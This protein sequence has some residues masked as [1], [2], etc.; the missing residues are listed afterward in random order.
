M[1]G[2]LSMSTRELDRLQVLVRV[3]E[4]RLTQREAARVLGVTERQLRRLW[5]AY[6]QRGAAGLVSRKRGRRSNR[7]LADALREDA[8]A[9]VRERYSDFGPTFAHEK[10]TEVHGLGVSVSTLRTWMADSGLWVPRVQRQRSVHQ[11][12]ARRECYG[13]LI[14]IDGSDHHWFEE[15]AGRCTLLVFIDDATGK[16]MELRFC[17]GESTFNYFEAAKSYLERHGKPVAFYSDKASVFRVNAKQPSAGD[18]YT[19]FGR[20]MGELNIDTMCA[21]TPQ[22]KGRVERANSTLQNRLVKELRL[23]NISSIDGA[24]RFASEF[25]E[26]FNKRFAHPALNPHDAHRPLRSDETLQKVFTWQETRKVTRSLTLHYKRAMYILD[27]SDAARRAMGKHVTLY[28]TED[29]EVSIVHDG[30]QLS[31]RAFHKEG[32]VHQAAIVENKLLGAALHYAKQMQQERD[33]KKLKS[34]AVTKRDKRLLRAR[35]A[36]AS[37]LP[38]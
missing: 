27:P 14:Q 3:S 24:N 20:A 5:T 26:D 4:R 30:H 15:R 23:A 33:D 19:Q 21:N 16:L 6:R 1:T 29:G 2:H 17:D 28:E 34:K 8:L 31:A 37:A 11:P 13:E 36:E 12:R 22:A 38:A 32:H 35:Q 9:L 18:G 10:L 25:M 7:R